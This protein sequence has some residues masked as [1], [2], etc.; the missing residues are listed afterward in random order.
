MNIEF[1]NES[2]L[3]DL[4]AKHNDPLA[5]AAEALKMIKSGELKLRERGAANTR[6]LIQLFYKYKTKKKTQIAASRKL[7]PFKSYIAELS[8]LNR[9]LTHTEDAMYTNGYDGFR[10]SMCMIQNLATTLSGNA[11]KPVN[12]STKFDGSPAVFLGINPD[13][14]KFFVA[15]KKIFNKTPIVNYTEAD[16]K[17]NHGG[18]GELVKILATVLKYAKDLRIK[19]G[20]FQGDLMYTPEILKKTSID[21]EPHWIFQPNTIAYAVPQDSEMGRSIG[22]SKIGIAFHTE[23]VGKT[24]TDLGTNYNIDVHTRMQK[25]KNVFFMDTGYKDVSGVV[26]FTKGESKELNSDIK[27]IMAIGRANRAMMNTIA[28]TGNTLSAITQYINR[29]VRS[30]NISFSVSGLLAFVSDTMKI[31]NT[32]RDR[33]TSFIHEYK[34]IL[35]QLFDLHGKIS[36]VKHR[37][38]RKLE[39]AQNMKHFLKKGDDLVVTAPEGYVAVDHIGNAIKLVDRLEFSKANFCK[40]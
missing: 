5:F 6:E 20:I 34:Y 37:I 16:I 39:T 17:T 13:N 36:S 23:Y 9:H 4:I 19:S 26:N 35:Q 14:G 11:I 10:A 38:I 32:G 30:G 29:E 33:L 27:E 12:L 31:S 18:N 15:T 28:K 2:V 24:L 40:E 3:T 22:K 8:G 25:N 21:G 7:T 1:L